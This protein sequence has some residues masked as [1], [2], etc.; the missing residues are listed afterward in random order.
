[1]SSYL[2]V[3]KNLKGESETG[4]IEAKDKVEVARGLRRQGFVPVTIE[5]KGGGKTKNFGG[6]GGFLQ[7]LL[8]FDVNR[9]LDS[10]RGVSLTDKIM[11]SRHLA[12]M[13]SAG[14]S[15]NRALEVLS[16]QTKNISFQ[17]AISS[18][19][20]GIRKGERIADAIE[21]YPKIFD[22]LYVSMVRSGDATGK[23]TE[24]LE[25]LADHLKKEHDLRSRIKGALMYPSVIVV[26]MGGIGALMMT[27]VVPKISAIFL[28][29]DVDLPFLTTVVIN[30]SNF[31]RDYWYIVFGSVPI[32]LFLFKKSASTKK[33]KK[34]LSGAFLKIPVLNGITRKINSARFSRTLS[35]LV[36]GGVPI[37][38][39][40][41]ITRDTLGNVYYR[42]S[43]DKVHKDVQQG[44]SL[45]EAISKFEN[46]YPGL[47]V[48]MVRVGE[49]SGALGSVLNRIAE[50]YEEE[51][52]NATKNLSSI[53]EPVLML[54]IGAVVGVF[55]VSMIQPMYSI[56]GNV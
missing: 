49:E 16:R 50:F 53:V 26:A 22:N 29:L 1:M 19:E 43:M 5:L 21:K 23:L 11:F 14:V 42:E 20:M 46:I 15:L 41:I 18:V 25:L 9:V 3:V 38:K 30:T 48:Q 51:V 39:S 13:V 37:L 55:A 27:M 17:N 4:T 45:Y 36:E 7:Y 40:I 28:D 12:V 44:T 35:S 32:F 34:F 10:I 47:I 2:Y 54:I 52:D 33:G 56:M 31:I 24:V 8:R 6:G